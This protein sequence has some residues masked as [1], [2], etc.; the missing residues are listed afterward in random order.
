MNILSLQFVF[1]LNQN[2]IK[3]IQVFNH[4]RQ[5]LICSEYEYKVK[6]NQDRCNRSKQLILIWLLNLLNNIIFLINEQ[7][8]LN[9][10]QRSI[11]MV[12]IYWN[13]L[14]KYVGICIHHLVH[15]YF[16]NKCRRNVRFRLGQVSNNLGNR[17]WWY[18]IQRI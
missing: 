10:L 9:Q 4:Y 11:E 3:I 13:N 8:E 14:I 18:L 2:H 1:N 15:F 17:F 12:I 5:I 6:T 7:Q 16:G